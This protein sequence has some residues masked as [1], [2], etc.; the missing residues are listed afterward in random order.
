MVDDS[1]QTGGRFRLPVFALALSGVL[2][3]GCS[4]EEEG[5]NPDLQARSKAEAPDQPWGAAADGEMLWDTPPLP[6]PMRVTVAG[7]SVP[8]EVGLAY[9]TSKWSEHCAEEGYGLSAEKLAEGFLADPQPLFTPF[10]RGVVLLREAEHRY[11]Q[12]P[13]EPLAQFRTQMEMAAG[14]SVEALIKRYGQDGWERHVERQFRLR[15]IKAEFALEAEEITEADVH[16]L[17]E[18]DVLSKLPSLD[19]AVGEDVSFEALESRLRAR[20]EVERANEAQERWIDEQMEG[21]EVKVEL[22]G[23]RVEEWTESAPTSE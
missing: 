17:Y 4:G 3:F 9:L 11:P 13:A 10:I 14:T 12:L 6:D 20:L 5:H 23:G 18:E 15:M 16:A 7:E 21:L 19:P 2:T 1:I 22:P 8:S